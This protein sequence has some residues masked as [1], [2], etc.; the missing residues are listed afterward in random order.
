MTKLSLRHVNNVLGIIIVALCLYIVLAPFWP[1]AALLIQKEPPL[2]AEQK[3]GSS[4]ETVPE[5]NTLVIP[6]LK[7][8]QTIHEGGEWV[9][10]KGVWHTPETGTPLAGNMVLSGHRFTYGGPAVFYHLDKLQEG[11]Q[12]VVYWQK[13]KFTYQVTDTLVVRPTENTVLAPSVSP[14]LTIYTCTPL[15]SAKDRLVIQA[16]LLEVRQ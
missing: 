9:L 14:K 16:E 10:N 6:K 12:I 8:Q 7:L 4:T 1:K 13:Q 11:D 2:V 5:E 15:W 3:S